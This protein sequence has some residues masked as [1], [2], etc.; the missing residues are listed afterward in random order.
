MVCEIIA[1]GGEAVA[2]T[3][4]VADFEQAEAMVRKA[5]ETFGGLDILVNNAGFGA[6]GCW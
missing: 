2:N 1:A 6:T 4:D 3:A 5:I